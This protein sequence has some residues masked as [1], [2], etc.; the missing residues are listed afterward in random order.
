MNERLQK[1]INNT[2]LGDI[3]LLTA[4]VILSL[5]DAYGA[6]WLLFFFFLKN[7]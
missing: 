2:D 1:F 6:G 7:C 5:N 3:L 4:I